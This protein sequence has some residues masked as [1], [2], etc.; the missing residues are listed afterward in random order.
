MIILLSPAKTLDYDVSVGNVPFTVPS[1]LPKSK[2]LIKILKS[3][4]SSEISQL[5]RLSDK[6]SLLN[7]NRYQSWKGHKKISKTSKQSVFVFK[8]D[9]YQGLK[10]EELSKK[11]LDFCQKH[12]RLLSGLYGVLRPLDVIEPYRL[13][14]GTKLESEQGKNLYDFWGRAISEEIIKEL[15]H[16][17]SDLLINLASKEYFNSIKSL[18]KKIKVISPIFK[19]HSKGNY[20]IISFYAKK[21]RGLMASWIIRNKITKTED[22][23]DFSEEGYF[24]SRRDSAEYTPM[25]LRN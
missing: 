24:F 12:L 1:L 7:T 14:M 18:P 19:D 13:E 6:L 5:M 25:F 9:V 3:K 21:A 2:Q 20:K 16:M 4:N 17:K 22:L 23:N 8:G 10:V 11:Q 15:D